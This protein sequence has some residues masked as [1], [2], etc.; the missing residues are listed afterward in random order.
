MLGGAGLLRW[1]RQIHAGVYYLCSPCPVHV[2]AGVASVTC[3]CGCLEGRGALALDEN[4]AI[5]YLL[6]CAGIFRF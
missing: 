2:S 6:N 3:K 4:Q 1:G 5:F